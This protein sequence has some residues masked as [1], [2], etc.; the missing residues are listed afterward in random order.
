MQLPLQ[1]DFD[2]NMNSLVIR[3]M[4]WYSLTNK[5]SYNK[6]RTLQGCAVVILVSYYYIPNVF[7]NLSGE[8]YK[9][10]FTC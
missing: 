3:Y 5:G 10:N 6:G 1:T 4:A 2:I 7:N 9:T 8:K